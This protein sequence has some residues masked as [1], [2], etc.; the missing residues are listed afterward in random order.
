MLVTRFGIGMRIYLSERQVVELRMCFALTKHAYKQGHQG[1]RQVMEEPCPP[2]RK[3]R[4][5]GLAKDNVTRRR[6]G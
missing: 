6:W 5:A 4:T 1:I 3:Q 2:A